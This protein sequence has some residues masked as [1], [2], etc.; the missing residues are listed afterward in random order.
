MDYSLSFACYDEQTEVLT[1][2]G[3]IPIIPPVM[4]KSGVA[5]GMG[6]FEQTDK[7]FDLI[8]IPDG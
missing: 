6:Y 2:E 8:L 1:K 4:L 7:K 5:R 3:F